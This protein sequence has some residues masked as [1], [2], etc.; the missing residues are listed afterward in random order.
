MN[1][2]NYRARWLLSK[3][4]QLCCTA[5]NKISSRPLAH[6]VCVSTTQKWVLHENLIHLAQQTIFVIQKPYA[7]KEKERRRAAVS[8]EHAN[9][10]TQG[11][12]RYTR[13]LHKHT[14]TNFLPFTNERELLTVEFYCTRCAQVCW[15]ETRVDLQFHL[16]ALHFLG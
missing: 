10:S 8:L 11:E 6:G 2:D 14:R 5:C 15:P 4:K 13:G 12:N 9:A 16:S 7:D 3:N 1:R